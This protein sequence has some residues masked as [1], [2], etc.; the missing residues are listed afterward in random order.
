MD[1]E[2]EAW[3]YLEGPEP[4]PVREMLDLL[5]ELS[6]ATDDDVADMERAIFEGLDAEIFGTPAALPVQEDAPVPTP[7]RARLVQLAQPDPEDA[8][9]RAIAEPPPP[10]PAPPAGALPTAVAPAALASTSPE[11][12]LK[13]VLERY[14]LRFKD[15]AD[16]SLPKP[17]K[18]TKPIPIFQD[19]KL[20]ATGPIDP[21]A[22]ARAGAPALPFATSAPGASPTFGGMNH[23]QYASFRA[24]LE[25]WP[26]WEE[27]ILVRY[28]IK[29]PEARLLLDD[30]WQ[31][32]LRRNPPTP[33]F[34]QALA[35]YTEKLRGR[36]ARGE[37]PPI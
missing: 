18:P 32:H 2:L 25:L 29:T 37:P 19:P 13:D 34:Q 14:R 31:Q 16:P 9:P 7:P 26:E 24:M 3:I 23:E 11:L 28:G 30:L 8:E 33:A 22:L 35:E 36:R 17:A 20:G 6:P 10:A 12:N 4:E 5:R 27:R 21:A 1:E 15:P